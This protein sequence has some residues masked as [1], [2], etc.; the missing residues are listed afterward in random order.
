MKYL[1]YFDEC[2]TMCTS[3]TK[4]VRFANAA[5]SLFLSVARC[6]VQLQD[7]F[8]E[9][10]INWRLVRIGDQHSSKVT[11]G[12]VLGKN[13]LHLPNQNPWEW[14]NPI[15]RVEP[16]YASANLLFHVVKESYRKMT[17]REETMG[18]YRKRLLLAKN[19]WVYLMKRAYGREMIDREAYVLLDLVYWLLVGRCLQMF[20]ASSPEDAIAS[21]PP[22]VGPNP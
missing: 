9:K 5:N 12:A 16:S 21:A 14:L 15:K 22:N 19:C 1:K 6:I 17:R 4:R 3:R 11:C 10:S 2:N 20:E 13:V 18:A 7:E 8:P